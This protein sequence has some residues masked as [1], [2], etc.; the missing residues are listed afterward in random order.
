MM[1]ATERLILREFVESDWPAVLA[2]QRDPLYLR[3]YHWSE[4]SET[5]VR[6]FVQMF[7]DNQQATP[8]RKFQLAVVCKADDQLIGNCG[9]RLDDE[10]DRTANI[11]YELAPA[12]WGNGYATEAARAIVAYGFRVLELHRIWSWCLAENVGSARVLEKVGMQREGRLR[13]NEHIKGRWWDTLIYGLLEDD[14]RAQ[15]P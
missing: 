10:H 15:Q 9:I 4:R 5:D 7:L 2:Y 3:Y 6:A 8:R 13:E 11:G 12:V 1:L 14:Y